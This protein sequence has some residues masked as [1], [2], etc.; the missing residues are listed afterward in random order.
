MALK[1]F[2][3]VRFKPS[4]AD[5]FVDEAGY[6]ALI[7]HLTTVQNY[8]VLSVLPVSPTVSIP[9][10]PQ[11]DDGVFAY[12]AGVVYIATLGRGPRVVH[13]L[14]TPTPPPG[15]ATVS[16]DAMTLSWTT[17]LFNYVAADYATCAYPAM[18]LMGR[19]LFHM[20]R[21]LSGMP[22][23]SSDHILNT[24]TDR[25]FEF[26]RHPN[27]WLPGPNFTCAGG[28][29]CPFE[30]RRFGDGGG[31]TVPATEGPVSEVGRHWRFGGVSHSI[32]DE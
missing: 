27:W 6:L 13:V 3:P 19:G 28:W 21:F 1:L 9:L 18:T 29:S 25:G 20:E 12:G 5:L 23:T 30:T 24:Y 22:G 2:S 31:L 16:T 10:N 8:D 11:A 7:H 32:H 4:N 17:M 14:C 15:R 26:A